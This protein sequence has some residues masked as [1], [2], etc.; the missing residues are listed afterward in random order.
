MTS[1][2]PALKNNRPKPN[3]ESAH[4]I[5]QHSPKIRRHE[6]IASWNQTL[7]LELGTCA[8]LA[9]SPE[10]HSRQQASVVWLPCR[11]NPL[12]F[13]S[14]KPY[15]SR[16]SS[17]FVTHDRSV[18]FSDCGFLLGYP[19]RWYAASFRLS[20]AENML[21]H[22]CSFMGIIASCKLINQVSLPICSK[23]GI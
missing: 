7:N 22:Q 9:P 19:S 13:P 15:S 10:S 2:R 17:V 16:Y 21:V 12:Y 8:T 20:L 14:A 5:A 1:W 11:V 18:H 4:R 6:V 3:S 23:S